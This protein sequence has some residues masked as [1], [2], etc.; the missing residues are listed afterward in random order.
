M[1]PALTTG[2]PLVGAPG[3]FFAFGGMQKPSMKM[4]VGTA[5]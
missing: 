2:R 4:K 1:N 5:C 3:C